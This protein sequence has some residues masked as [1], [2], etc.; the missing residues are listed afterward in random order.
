MGTLPSP[1]LHTYS[2][3]DGVGLAA[4]SGHKPPEPAVLMYERERE[5]ENSYSF[6]EKCPNA[7]R[8][9]MISKNTSLY[10]KTETKKPQPDPGVW[11]LSL[12]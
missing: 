3:L 10:S 8:R 5:R 6:S 7:V 2:H 11:L 9:H 4:R 12:L 1:P